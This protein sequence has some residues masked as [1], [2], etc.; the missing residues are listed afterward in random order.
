MIKE[1][2]TYKDDNGNEKT[3]VL[4][5]HMGMNAFGKLMK[6][7]F[8]KRANWA[9]EANRNGDD[10]G[11]GE[12]IGVIADIIKVSYGTVETDED[13]TTRFVRDDRKTDSFLDSKAYDAFLIKM[14]SDNTGI[15]FT[16]FLNNLVPD[17]PVPETEDNNEQP[18]NQAVPQTASVPQMPATPQVPPSNLI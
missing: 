2:V 12:M 11:L 17:L 7:D 18:N 10:R 6:T 16:T 5:F 1:T 14:L 3:E 8:R 13:G 15:A 9:V 4:H